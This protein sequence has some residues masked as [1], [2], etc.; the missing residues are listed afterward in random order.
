MWI[1]TKINALQ[2]NNGYKLEGTEGFLQRAGTITFL[3]STTQLQVWFDDVLEVTWVYEDKGDGASCSLRT[4]MTGLKFKSPFDKY[5][6]VSSHYRYQL[7]NFTLIT[8]AYYTSCS[9]T[10]N[11]FTSETHDLRRQILDFKQNLG[12]FPKNAQQWAMVTSI[13]EILKE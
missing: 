2:C 7:G 8:Y 10:A 6:K 1:C 9:L 13:H 12:V 5:D 3:K 11:L 4:S